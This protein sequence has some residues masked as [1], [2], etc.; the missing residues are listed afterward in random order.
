MPLDQDLPSI[1]RPELERVDA[2]GSR[3]ALDRAAAGRVEEVELVDL[4]DS[5]DDSQ[6]PSVRCPGDPLPLGDRLG[7]DLRQAGP[8]IAY[9][10]DID[11]AEVRSSVD[12][13]D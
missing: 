11:R 2:R 3:D 7:R 5:V 8:V 13:P 1:G 4:V 10:V 9:D 12:A 6:M